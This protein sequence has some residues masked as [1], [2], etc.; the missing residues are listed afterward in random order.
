MK[1]DR[2]ALISRVRSAIEVLRHGIRSAVDRSELASSHG[3]LERI[4]R[5]LR[6]QEAHQRRLLE[7][8]F[9]CVFCIVITPPNHLRLEWASD[10]F[11]EV[12]GLSPDDL[13][14]D[15]W[16][17]AIHPED[18]QRVVEYG[19][20]ISAGQLGRCEFR[21][22]SQEGEARWVEASTRLESS[23][24]TGERFYY[25]AVRRIDA[26][27][28]AEA[29]LLESAERFAALSDSVLDVM[30]EI[31]DGGRLRFVSSSALEVFGRS[32]AD[33]VG[34][35][36]RELIHPDDR[37]G[38]RTIFL[39]TAEASTTRTTL[40]LLRG[41]GGVFWGEFA[42][43]RFSSREGEL[44]IVVTVRDVSEQVEVEERLR[45]QRE[46]LEHEVQRR[47]REMRE[48]QSRLLQA[49]RLGALEDLAGSV[50][51][52]INNPLAALIGTAELAVDENPEPRIQRV[53]RLGYR[54]RDVV[55]RTLTLYRQGKI[56]RSRERASAILSE[57]RD[58]FSERSLKQGV[59]LSVDIGEGLPGLTIDRPLLTA[60]LESLAENAL[61][62]M[63]EGG[64]LWLTAE[65][66]QEPRVVTFI[67]AD[68]GPGIAP[69][70]R[71]K[72][73]EPF[74]T[75]RGGGTGLGLSIAR[76]IVMGHEGRICVGDR[77][78]GGAQITVEIPLS[79]LGRSIASR[80]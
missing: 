25:G 45:R 76:G 49:E 61:D 62:A 15:D 11:F 54:V 80:A 64:E 1:L 46:E 47:T 57:V 75:T 3:E 21:L 52:A 66:M 35:Y 19:L 7:L 13:P 60:A 34:T 26:R 20:R 23:S 24:P 16:R 48:L 2:P 10:S 63:P 42:A 70:E 67:V 53:L 68:T 33:L 73:F 55:A 29:E 56:N 36:A 5:Q 22:I 28:Q 43:R 37:L 39:Q 44:G 40:R 31:A 69:E 9:D 78:G 72:V 4:H 59:N 30:F 32:S 71:E 50:A 27:K 65:V 79:P 18:Q 17:T 8:S 38:A 14:L 41:D 12:S 77:P 6:E 58:H 74:Y 51:H